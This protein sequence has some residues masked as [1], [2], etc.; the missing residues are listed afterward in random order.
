[1]TATARLCRSWTLTTTNQNFD[2][3]KIR[4]WTHGFLILL[5]APTL[6]DTYCPWI[7]KLPPHKMTLLYAQRMGKSFNARACK[8]LSR[9]NITP[10]CAWLLRHEPRTRPRT[11][12]VLDRY[13]Y[14]VTQFQPAR[15]PLHAGRRG[16]ISEAPSA[17][18][19][20]RSILFPA[21]P[22]AFQAAEIKWRSVFVSSLSLYLSYP[23]H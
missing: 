14:R 16:W 7:Q 3:W 20:I 18:R 23:T 6:T 4:V 12:I 1:M 15:Q 5:D 17:R 11:W 13:L 21:P 9:I 8:I 22:I 19:V 2:L 10:T